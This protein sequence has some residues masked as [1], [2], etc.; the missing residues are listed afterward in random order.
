M[1]CLN[2]TD[3]PVSAPVTITQAHVGTL[4]RYLHP[5]RV[6]WSHRIYPS[7]RATLFNEMEFALP[8]ERG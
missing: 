5:E 4:E 1:K 8:L 7:V 2:S 6:D 3:E